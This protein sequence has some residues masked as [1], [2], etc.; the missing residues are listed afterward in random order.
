[1]TGRPDDRPPGERLIEARVR[2]AMKT[3]APGADVF[4]NV[5][6]LTSTRSGGPPRDGETDLLVVHPEYG[7]LAIEVKD[8][9]VAGTR[10]VRDSP[11]RGARGEPVR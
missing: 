5:R 11:G 4:A 10:S 3:A 2:D 1:V 6:W 8:G 7:I 9:L